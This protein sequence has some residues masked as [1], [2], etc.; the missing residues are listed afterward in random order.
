MDTSETGMSN[1]AQLLSELFQQYV[2]NKA[3]SIVKTLFVELL[4]K[5][6][7]KLDQS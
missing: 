6:Q 3:E 7:K 2:W 5:H 1:G 4:T